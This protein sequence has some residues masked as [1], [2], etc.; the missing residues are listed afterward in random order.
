MHSWIIKNK[1]SLAPSAL[2]GYNLYFH[3]LSCAIIIIWTAYVAFKRALA[4]ESVKIL[5][6]PKEIVSIEPVFVFCKSANKNFRF[7]QIHLMYTLTVL[8]KEIK[9]FRGRG[10]GGAYVSY[11]EL[12]RQT[13]GTLEKLPTQNR[14]YRGRIQVP[15]K[16][17]RGSILAYATPWS[18]LLHSYA[19]ICLK[20]IIL[21]YSI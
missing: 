18:G 5:R 9:S 14:I 17:Y 20:Y 12:P 16:N 7:L 10:R 11:R 4:I 2:A 1:I 3:Q 8:I 21:N 6:N 19:S 15:S 13:S